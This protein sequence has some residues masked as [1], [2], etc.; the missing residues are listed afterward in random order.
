MRWVIAAAAALVLAGLYLAVVLRFKDGVSSSVGDVAAPASPVP[1][2]PADA[3]S[4][5]EAFA[6]DPS[7]SNSGIVPAPAEPGPPNHRPKVQR[8]VSKSVGKAMRRQFTA[9]MSGLSARLSNCPDRNAQA[10]FQDFDPS[11]LT[12]LM[13]DIE[14]LEGGME[15]VDV[16]LGPNGSGTAALLACARRELRGQVIP[17]PSATQGERMQMPLWLEPQ[18]SP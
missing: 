3:P 12:I 1:V 6:S 14:P 5:R 9:A 13:L 18:L 11:K 15:I 8:H 10:D 16:S 7:M 4:S 17:S 2:A